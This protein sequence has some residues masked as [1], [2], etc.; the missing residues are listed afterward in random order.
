MSGALIPFALLYAYGV[1]CLLRGLGNA[2]LPLI[3]IAIIMMGATVSEIVV[4]RDVFASE[5]N[6]FHLP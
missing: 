4:N 5:H 1:I 3:A 2:L 6:W